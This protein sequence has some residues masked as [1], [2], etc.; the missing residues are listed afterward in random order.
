MRQIYRNNIFNYGGKKNLF[1]YEKIFPT[2]V[3]KMKEIVVRE[4]LLNELVIEN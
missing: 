3:A 1:K 2:R 4:K